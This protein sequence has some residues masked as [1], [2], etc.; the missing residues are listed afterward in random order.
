MPRVKISLSLVAADGACIRLGGHLQLIG[1]TPEMDDADALMD[2]FDAEIADSSLASDEVSQRFPA[3]AHLAPVA[4]GALLIRFREPRDGILW[5][6]GEMARTVRWAGKPDAS[7]VQTDDG[8][9]LSPR[10]SF[11]AWEEVQRGRSLPWSLNEIEAAVD[12]ECVV[13][14]MLL[15]RLESQV[16]ESQAVAKALSIVNTQLNAVM[17]STSSCILQIDFD[18]VVLYGNRKAVESRVGFEIGKDF[19]SGFPAISS[20]VAEVKLRTAMRE[21][22]ETAYQTHSTVQDQ[23]YEVRA[24]PTPD[25]LSI[26]FS[27][28]SASKK[29]QEQLTVEQILRERRIEALSHMAGG[30]AHEISNPLA[31]IH[32]TASDLLDLCGSESFSAAEVRTPCETILKTADRATKILRG[33]RG[34]A[35]EGQKDPLEMAS[36]PGIIQQCMDLQEARFKRHH[37]RMQLEIEPDMPFVW[38]REI[39]IMQIVTNLLNNAFDAVVQSHAAGGWVTLT[40]KLSGGDTW[41]EVGDSGPGIADHF[42]AHLMEP[43]FTTKEHG[44]GMG[45]GLSLSRAIAQDHGGSLTLCEGTPHTL[46][47][48]ILPKAAQ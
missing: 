34:F 44:L 41:I 33:L 36:V 17:D 26:F 35:R 4:S 38:C 31:I 2:A 32:A 15:H 48:L 42:K 16:T 5:L 6:R 1:A 46:F 3:F 9:R 8:L 24:F 25:G 22:A 23:W 21:R 18:W 7:K 19:W 11:A 39:Q 45:V 30:L 28:I 37:L 10:K 12:L 13:A 14:K 47:R 40:A 29:L 20:P 27:D 43:F